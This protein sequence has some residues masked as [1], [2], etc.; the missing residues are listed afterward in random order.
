MS[1]VK[2]TTEYQN[3]EK[4]KIDFVSDEE[5]AATLGPDYNFPL[6]QLTF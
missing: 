5:L 6:S 1:P 3:S 4:V 2:N